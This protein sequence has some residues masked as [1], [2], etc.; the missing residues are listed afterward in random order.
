MAGGCGIT[1][2]SFPTPDVVKLTGD[3][4]DWDELGGFAQVQADE[5]NEVLAVLDERLAA[6]ATV[7]DRVTAFEDAFRMVATWRS[8]LAVDG[9]WTRPGSRAEDFG[10]PIAEGRWCEISPHFRTRDKESP[11]YQRFA[12]L[13]EIA[14]QRLAGGRVL[15]NVVDLRDGRTIDGNLLKS[16][17]GTNEVVTETA[18]LEHR[19]ELRR[20][21]FEAL[22]RLEAKRAEAGRLDAHDPESRQAFTDAAYFLIQAPQ[23]QRG[24]DAV[25]RTFLVAAYTRLFDEALRL[26][27]AVDLDGMVRGQ[28]GFSAVM[29][30]D[31]QVA[32]SAASPAPDVALGARPFAPGTWAVPGRNAASRTREVTRGR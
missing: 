9:T 19:E 8:Q 13:E 2:W 31:L 17:H 22:A 24:S 28:D 7:E 20:A 15:Q 26:P 11:A 3:S 4:A 29:A 10:K 23:V 1:A 16:V 27:E 14:L 21:S 12:A 6:A 32:S 30:K 18:T 5:A 25:M